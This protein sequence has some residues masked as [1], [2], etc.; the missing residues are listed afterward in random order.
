MVG[1]NVKWVATSAELN[2]Y[3]KSSFIISLIA[4]FVGVPQLLAPSTV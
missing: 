2:S 4:F 1:R 3:L